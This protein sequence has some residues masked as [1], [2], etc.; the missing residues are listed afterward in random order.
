MRLSVSLFR[1]EVLS[2]RVVRPG[3]ESEVKRPSGREWGSVCLA[4]F[5]NPTAIQRLNPCPRPFCKAALTAGP[6]LVLSAFSHLAALLGARGA[7]SECELSVLAFD[8]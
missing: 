2:L 3:G 8:F 7:E 5:G 4:Q 1:W 6:L